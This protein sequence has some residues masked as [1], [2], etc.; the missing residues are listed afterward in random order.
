MK[1]KYEKPMLAVENY[2]LSQTIAACVTKIGFRNEECVL[3]DVDATFQAKNLASIGFF[4]QGLLRS[5]CSLQAT[6]MDT[7]D[8]ICFHTNAAAM[9]TS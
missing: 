3:K 8:A 4:S 1:L 6:G 7:M 9:F 5:S 2:M